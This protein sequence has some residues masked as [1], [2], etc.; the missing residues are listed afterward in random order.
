VAV[1]A[2]ASAWLTMRFIGLRRDA[3]PES[4]VEQAGAV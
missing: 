3:H 4:P 2:A 1:L